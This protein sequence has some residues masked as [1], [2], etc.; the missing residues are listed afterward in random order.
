MVPLMKRPLLLLSASLALAACR[1]EAP[2]TPAPS[3]APT[4]GVAAETVEPTTAAPVTVAEPALAIEGEGLRL[5]DPA[6]GSARPLPFGMAWERVQEALAY[7]GKPATGRNEECGAGPLDYAQWEDSLTLYGQGG[8]FVG[9]FID[10]RAEGRISTAAGVGPGTT[11]QD[12]EAAYA[13]EVFESTLGTE[14]A[15]GNLSGVLDSPHPDSPVSALWAGTSC[16]FR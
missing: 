6:T 1:G 3:A 2:P 11:R 16:N 13:A 5:F 15:A 8:Q 4:A 12:L 9:W 7:R 10:S 14:F